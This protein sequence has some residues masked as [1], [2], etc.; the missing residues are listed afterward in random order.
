MVL[1]DAASDG[2]SGLS[3]K[4][5]TDIDHEVFDRSWEETVQ[6]VILALAE[7]EIAVISGRLHHA[8][9]A[10]D[11]T[12]LLKS[13]GVKFLLGLCSRSRA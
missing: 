12:I 5:K 13:Q 11:H 3:Q 4:C 7:A 1:E 8:S 10:T 9:T 6:T 2:R